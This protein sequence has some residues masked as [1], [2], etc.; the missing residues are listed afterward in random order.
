[1]TL[2]R[3]SDDAFCIMCLPGNDKGLAEL[4]ET[5]REAVDDHLFEI[6]G[7]TVSLTVSIGVSAITENSPKAEELLSRVHLASAEVKSSQ[8][9][10]TGMALLY[11]TRLILRHP[12]NRTPS[13]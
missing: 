7:R 11:T 8:G 6:N 10:K 3:L 1:M 9:I 4:C 2:A 12:M 13:K 5:I